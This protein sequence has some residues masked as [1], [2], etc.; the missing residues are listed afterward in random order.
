MKIVGF[1]LTMRSLIDF[2]SDQMRGNSI[3]VVQK[4]I[5]VF[6]RSQIMHK[7]EQ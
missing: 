6:S 7:K 1:R 5:L 3:E 2:F 4:K